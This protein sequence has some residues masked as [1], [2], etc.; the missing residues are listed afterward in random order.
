[1]KNRRAVCV[2]CL[3][4]LLMAGLAGSIIAVGPTFPPNPYCDQGA[5][6]SCSI[7][8]S[9]LRKARRKRSYALRGAGCPASCQAR[10][11][12]T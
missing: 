1:M 10:V 4:L 5:L 9:G 2:F 12:G 11:P 3:A 7:G 8:C 6:C